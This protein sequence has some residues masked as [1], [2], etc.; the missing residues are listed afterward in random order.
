MC[1]IWSLVNVDNTNNPTQCLVTSNETNCTI[2]MS[3]M[4]QVSAG[5][6]KN[7]G[8]PNN[9]QKVQQ[10]LGTNLAW[11]AGENVHGFSG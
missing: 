10:F 5:T 2:W 6:E 1:D 8:A 4:T 3:N 11:R 9:A 7:A